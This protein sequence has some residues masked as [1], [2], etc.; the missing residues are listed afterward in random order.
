MWHP[1]I[2]APHMKMTGHCRCPIYPHHFGICSVQMLLVVALRELF[3]LSNET[4]IQ[5][6]S[7]IVETSQ[8]LEQQRGGQ[9]PLPAPQA[10]ISFPISHTGCGE[11]T[12]QFSFLFLL[13]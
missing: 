12:P 9:A 4:P 10:H 2:R 11:K 1:F 6:G 7:R 5:L 8:G 13:E 3:L